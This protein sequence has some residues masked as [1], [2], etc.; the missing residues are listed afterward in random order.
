MMTGPFQR[1][2]GE[3]GASLVEFAIVL[4]LFVLLVFGIME[5]GWFFSQSVELRNAAREGARLAV[6]DYGSGPDIRVETC[7]RAS[8][9]GSGATVTI[10]LS[11]T[12]DTSFDPVSPES[13]TVTMSKTYESLTGI[14]NAP[15]GGTAMSSSA[16]MRT[17]RPL[18]NLTS[19]HTGLC[20]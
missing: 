3:R 1:D 5:A 11:T 2:R 15:L 14:L 8:L 4:P 20:P 17:E 19:G 12:A 7:N 13:I 10:D 6:I 16:E 9:S 18:V